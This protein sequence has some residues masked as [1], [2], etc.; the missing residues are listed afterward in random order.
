MVRKVLSGCMAFLFLSAVQHAAA[1]NAPTLEGL[2]R[3]VTQLKER[4]EDQ[5]RI[6]EEQKEKIE[7]LEACYGECTHRIDTHE[8]KLSDVMPG[9]KDLSERLKHQLQQLESAAGFE[10]GAGATF[11]AQGTPNAN[12]AGSTGG[13]TED[14]RLDASY[15]T[16]VTIAKKFNEYGLGFLAMETGAGD[17]VEGDLS[18][19]PGCGVNRDADMSG[20]VISITQAWYEHYFLDGQIVITGGRLEAPAYIDTNEF[21]NDE[22]TQF[23]GSMFRNSPVVEFPGNNIGLRGDYSPKELSAVSIT[24]LYMGADGDWEEVI[25]KP[26]C[27]VQVGFMPEKA[28]ELDESMWRGEYRAYYWCNATDHTDL[29]DVSKTKETNYGFGL[30][31]DQ[32]ITDVFGVF[33]R[34]GWQNPEVSTLEYHWSFGGRMTGEYWKREDD[35]LAVAIGQAIPGRDYRDTVSEHRVETHIETY[36][37][38]KVND[39]LTI[40]P[41]LQII[42]E[43]NGNDEDDTITVYGVRAQVD[44]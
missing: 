24:G 25:N 5:G 41:D 18:L 31:C 9:E 32:N 35:I 39:H 34:F 1:Q 10:M 26:F 8:K 23:L 29:S 30:S 27:A 20:S 16:A 44:L 17:A 33:G 43:P 37:S 36:Y 12:N 15:S 40:S 13:S 11:I 28:F 42:W 7:R 22:T 21:A 3:E 14:S 2:Y 19:Y 4:V 6:I 38:F